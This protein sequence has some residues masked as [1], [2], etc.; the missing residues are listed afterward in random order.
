M[1]FAWRARVIHSFILNSVFFNIP[2]DFFAKI[3]RWNFRECTK[4]TNAT[5]V[6][7]FCERRSSKVF[8]RDAASRYPLSTTAN[9]N[10]NTTCIRRVYQVVI[11]TSRFTIAASAGRR[12]VTWLPILFGTGQERKL[13]SICPL[14]SLASIIRVL[15][16]T[17]TGSFLV[18]RKL[19]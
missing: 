2:Q 3:S 16:G 4:S 12:R 13:M 8:A 19:C 14:I 15:N 7:L 1:K 18:T 6:I 10:T 17:Y 5:I 9:T 11:E